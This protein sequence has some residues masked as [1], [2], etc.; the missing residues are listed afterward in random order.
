MAAPAPAAAAGALEA[1][2]TRVKVLGQGSFGRAVLVASK[3]D[4]RQYVI[5]EVDLGQMSKP[6]RDAAH[7]EAQ[8]RARRGAAARGRGGARQG[9]AAGRAARRPTGAGPHGGV[10]W[11]AGGARTRARA[12]KRSRAPRPRSSC[13]S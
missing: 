4:G 8:A 2:F 6:E 12:R 13:A 1:R 3:E 10:G 7:Q 11:P 9:T 5:K